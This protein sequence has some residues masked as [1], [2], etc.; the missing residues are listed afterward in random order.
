MTNSSDK[1][2]YLYALEPFQILELIHTLRS[3]HVK[4]Y[5]CFFS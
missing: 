4:K 5:Y 3:E 1:A 2:V